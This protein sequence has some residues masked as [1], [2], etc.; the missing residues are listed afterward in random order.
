MPLVI[1]LS[2]TQCKISSTTLLD[3]CCLCWKLI[4][5]TLYYTALVIL[6]SS[7]ARCWHTTWQ[8]R[9]LPT[10]YLLGTI[11]CCRISTSSDLICSLPL[12]HGCCS[13]E[14][15]EQD[16]LR[17]FS[18]LVLGWVRKEQRSRDSE[19]LCSLWINSLM[20]ESWPFPSWHSRNLTD[21]PVLA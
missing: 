21:Y 2:T 14:S 8:D 3:K 16:F 1:L 11:F 5:A 4:N 20:G 7:P 9:A 15:H 13:H 6:D 18:G 17:F 10:L 12:S 19:N